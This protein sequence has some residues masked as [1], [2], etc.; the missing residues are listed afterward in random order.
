MNSELRNEFDMYVN[1]GDWVREL[2]NFTQL[3]FGIKK[4]RAEGGKHIVNRAFNLLN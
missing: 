4:Y 3:N 2:V 1:P